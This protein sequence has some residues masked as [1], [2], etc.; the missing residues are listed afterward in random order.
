MSGEADANFAGVGFLPPL[1]R[2]SIIGYC[3]HSSRVVSVKVRVSG[4]KAG[5]LSCYAPHSGYPVADRQAFFEDVAATCN[6]LS[7]H[8]PLMLL[9]D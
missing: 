8:V 3:S 5:F 4:G 7:H 6:R 2:R 9:G 1:L